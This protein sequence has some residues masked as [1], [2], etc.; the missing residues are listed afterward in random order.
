MQILFGPGLRMA[1]MEALNAKA[2]SGGVVEFM[3]PLPVQCLRRHRDKGLQG[4]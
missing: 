3:A 1:E 4:W 2:R